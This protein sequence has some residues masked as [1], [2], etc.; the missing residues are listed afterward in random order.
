MDLRKLKT[1]I[2]LVAES[3]IS[4]L[5][6]NEGEDRVRIVNAGSPAPTGQV[7]YANPAP[8]VMQA[9]PVAAIPVAAAPIAETPAETGFVARSP[10]VGTF[11]RAPNPESPDFVKVGDSVK[12]GQTLC[13]IEAMKLLNEI[14]AEKEGVI[15]Q[16]LCEN[17]Q[18]VEFDQP[19]FIIA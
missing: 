3:G 7:V 11:Y 13:I 1:L 5:E 19:L 17:G 9:A 10:M 8:Q 16:I 2:D 12:V 18:G 14:E 15:K 4:E 6:V